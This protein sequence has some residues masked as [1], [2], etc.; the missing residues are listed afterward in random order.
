MAGGAYAEYL[1][2]P[3]AIAK[4]NVHIIPDSLS[5][6]EA[7]LVEPLACALYAVEDLP[8]RLGD[9]VAIPRGYHP[10]SAAPGYELCYCFGLSSPHG[11]R[12]GAWQTDPR[13][14]WLLQ[15]PLSGR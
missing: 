10:I 9:A 5:F 8:L 6:E 3:A 7:A 1:F 13:H 12:F 11:R 2:V 14:A 4:N 15:E